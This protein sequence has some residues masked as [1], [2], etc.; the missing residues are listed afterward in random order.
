MITTEK[1]F[2][3]PISTNSIFFGNSD[4]NPKSSKIS[5]LMSENLDYPSNDS[6][7]IKTNQFSRVLMND[8]EF[9]LISGEATVQ[10]DKGVVPSK[11]LS[12]TPPTNSWKN[13]PSDSS[14]LQE[15]GFPLDH[16]INPQ[17]TTK[18]TSNLA[19]LGKPNSLLTDESC[20]LP[21]LAPLQNTDFLFFF[22]ICSLN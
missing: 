5:L 3:R 14:A 12:T 22:K 11:K 15:A 1:H 19:S 21:S 16:G 13:S 10:L 18:S 8:N 20:K 9:S 6:T 7:K 4:Q 17:T 2:D